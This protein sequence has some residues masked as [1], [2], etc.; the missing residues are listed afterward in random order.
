MTMEQQRL[1]THDLAAG[2]HTAVVDGVTVTARPGRLL[3]L[4]GPNGAGKSTVLKTLIGQLAPVAGTVFLDGEDLRRRTPVEI[5]R[6]LAAVM[7]ERP[8]PELMTCFDVAAAGRYPYTGRL[9]LLR[10]DDRAAV[11]EAMALVQVSELRDR[12]FTRISD[13]QRQ[14]VLLAR[15]ICQEPA[16]L[17]LDEPT[18]Y[19]DIRHKMDFMVLLRRLARQRQI[20][21]ILSLHELELAQRFSDEILCLKE[22]RVDR[23]GTP[24]EIFSGGYVASL[25]GMEAESYLETQGVAEPPAVR[26]E[27][28][29]FVIGGG[30]AGIP[31]Y[32]RLSRLGIPFAAGIL[33]GNDVEL[34]VAGALAA[35]V[36][37]E[38]PFVPF[39]EETAQAALALLRTCRAVLCPRTR[40]GPVNAAN[41][42]LRDEA[43][44]LGLLLDERE[45]E[46]RFG[47]G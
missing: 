35:A 36:V 22:G 32:R 25:Y 3:T 34:P 28:Q 27:P 47:R 21:V 26:G 20:A 24:E 10:S 46:E 17:V 2:Y 16:V 40:F 43:A 42:R 45:L 8:A 18:G 31:C 4:I 1:Y 12:E 37:R 15:A 39:R 23:S 6:R 13:G 44:R 9:G 38:E 30:G 29:V 41:G 11:E 19:L 7:T 33:A 5:A 14:R